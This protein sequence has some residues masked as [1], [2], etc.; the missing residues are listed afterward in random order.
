MSHRARGG[1][2]AGG[3]GYQY[4]ADWGGYGPTTSGQR[5]QHH[6]IRPSTPPAP[7]NKGTA[8]ESLTAGGIWALL[9]TP[10]LALVLALLIDLRPH[11]RVATTSPFFGCV[12]V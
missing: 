5:Q 4:E 6:E 10:Y 1:G 8:L 3:G 12:R 9:C 2:A 7:T 11:Y